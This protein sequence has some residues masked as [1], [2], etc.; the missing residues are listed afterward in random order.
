MKCITKAFYLLLVIGALAGCA[1]NPKIEDLSAE[2]QSKVSGVLIFKG[3]PETPFD[4]IG[5][6]DGLSCHR[7]AYVPHDVS[8]AEATEGIKIRTVILGG[9]A[10]IHLTCE[11]SGVDWANNCWSSM[12]CTADA[13]KLK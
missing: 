11:S 6:V 7:N 13:V 1:A 9:N 2:D 5:K 4:V 3:Q 8:E 12:K 10:A